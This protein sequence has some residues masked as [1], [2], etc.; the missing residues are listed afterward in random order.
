M[1]ESIL[2]CQLMAVA[3]SGVLTRGSSLQEFL[4][5]F[6]GFLFSDAFLAVS[7][8]VRSHWRLRV[9]LCSLC[10]KQHSISGRKRLG[11]HLVS[12]PHNV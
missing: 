2:T 7:I 10:R 8:A 3:F 9:S 11:W 12:I 5:C 1:I 4:T 6:V